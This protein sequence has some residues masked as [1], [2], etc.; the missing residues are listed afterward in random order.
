MRG[1]SRVQRLRLPCGSSAHDPRPSSGGHTEENDWP[2]HPFPTCTLGPTLAA[3]H[4]SHLVRTGSLPLL[5]AQEVPLAAA[6]E[7][8]TGLHHLALQ[9]QEQPGT[10]PFL[11]LW[12]ADSSGWAKEHPLWWRLAENPNGPSHRCAHYWTRYV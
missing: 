6:Q 10:S 4:G 1:V 2:S 8:G 11:P 12:V 3:S 7:M 9:C 5:S